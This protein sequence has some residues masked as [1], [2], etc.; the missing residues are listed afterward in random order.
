M[1]DICD[2]VYK[3][4]S[5]ASLNTTTKRSDSAAPGPQSPRPFKSLPEPWG[6]GSGQQPWSCGGDLKGLGLQLLLGAPDPFKSSC[7]RAAAPF[8]SSPISCPA[9][10]VAMPSY[11]YA[12]LYRTGLLTPLDMR[13]PKD[14]I[15]A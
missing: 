4:S 10:A 13:P 9:G 5:A 6:S 11:R 12:I 8:G 2:A 14:V 7:P 3:Y 15:S 1:V